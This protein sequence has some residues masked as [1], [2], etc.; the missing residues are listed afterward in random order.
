MDVSIN[1]LRFSSAIHPIPFQLL[2]KLPQFPRRLSKCRAS[3]PALPAPFL[4]FAPSTSRGPHQ[5]LSRQ[6]RHYGLFRSLTDYGNNVSKGNISQNAR[7]YTSHNHIS[8][9]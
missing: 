3:V 9:T 4:F 2:E 6:N 1:T 8:W 7:Q 5:P